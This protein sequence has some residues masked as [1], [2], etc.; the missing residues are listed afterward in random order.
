[1]IS[2]IWT[3]KSN[4]GS[5]LIRKIT[6]GKASHFSICFDE[7]V[8]FQSTINSGCHLSFN[9]IFLS[10]NDVVWRI[11]LALGLEMEEQIWQN[12]ANLDGMPYDYLG[13]LHLASQCLFGKTLPGSFGDNRSYMCIEVAR[14]LSPFIPVPSDL[15]KMIPDDVYEFFE[16]VA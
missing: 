2:L 3:K 13:A 7:K 16:K 8:V 11:D 15:S 9:S 5:Y 10:K 4:L 6:G 14:A 1:M 12:C